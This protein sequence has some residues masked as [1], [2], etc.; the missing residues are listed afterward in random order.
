MPNIEFRGSSSAMGFGLFAASSGPEPAGSYT[1]PMGYAGQGYQPFDPDGAYTTVGLDL[2][3]AGG[4][5]NGANGG[6]GGSYSGGT[7]LIKNGGIP[8]ASLY[9][10]TPTTASYGQT[11]QATSYAGNGGNG[12]STT[13]P[14]PYRGHP[15]GGASYA[16]WTGGSMVA[17][18]GGG[19][20]GLASNHPGRKRNGLYETAPSSGDSRSTGGSRTFD[21]T[22]SGRNGGN[23]SNTPSCYYGGGAGGGG[24][25]QGG[26]GAAHQNGGTAG[27]HLGGSVGSNGGSDGDFD[28]YNVNYAN[29]NS[30]HATVSWS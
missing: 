22:N 2:R 25:H 15:G 11:S 13:G 18:G 12:G 8:T 9:I 27:G 21:Q 20:G 28:S 1:H 24:A 7:R 30:A 6:G 3:G 29:N 16:T 23:G 10:Y 14:T 5:G 17:A 4:Q 19:T 26:Y